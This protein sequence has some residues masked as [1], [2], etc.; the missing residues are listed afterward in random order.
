MIGAETVKVNVIAPHFGEGEWHY[1]SIHPLGGGLAKS[2][3][4]N[5][6]YK[7]TMGQYSLRITFWSDLDS[8][9]NLRR[10]YL[11]GARGA[12]FIG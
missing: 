2:L 1:R 6:A 3:L 11:S 4:Q 9:Y 10:I 12:N 5:H 8:S 7:G